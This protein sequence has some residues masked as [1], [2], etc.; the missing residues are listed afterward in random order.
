MA[1]DDW[2]RSLRFA[3]LALAA[4]A[5]VAACSSSSGGETPGANTAELSDN[6]SNCPSWTQGLDVYTPALAHEGSTYKFEV[7]DI[8]PPPPSPGNMTWTLKVVD[9]SG[10][11]VT[12]AT[13]ATPK[14]WMPQ[15]MHS[16]TA[17]PSVQAN[18]DGTFTVTNLY[19]YMPG[20]WQVTFDVQSGSTADSAVFT[21][22]LGT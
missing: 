15:H 5:G 4:G 19:L 21:F 16:S 22:C 20:V 14:T 2:T 8:S 12:D 18:G 9:A 17:Q 13:M 3:G 1:F 6:A 10:Q 11:P 7:T